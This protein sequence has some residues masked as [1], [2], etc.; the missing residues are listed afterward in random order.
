MK[1][2]KNIIE[3]KNVC[4]TYKMSEDVEVKAVCNANINVER[5]DF[6]AIMGPSGSGK[7]TMM[8]LVGA[9]DLASEGDIFLDN[10]NIEHLEE[11]ELAQI[12]G[13]RIGFI[14]QG[15]NL[16]P[17]LTARENIMLPMTFQDYTQEE[18]EAKA[19]ELLKLVELE[20][21]AYHYPNQL[22]GGQQQRV[23]I[24]RALANNPEVILADEPTG[25]LD[26]K[27]GEKVMSFLEEFNKNGKTIIMVTH[28]SSLAEKHARK[29]YWLKDGEVER[30][31]V[32]EKGKWKELR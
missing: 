11:S 19:L 21:R 28:D 20:D 26:S 25:N 22:S 29:I 32:K 16:I 3:L 15:F 1:Q 5:G 12:R 7:S 4:K 27:T 13:R 6:V 18:R 2:E 17:N 14:F 10:I 31:T 8:N 24:A 23:A 9:L 30:V